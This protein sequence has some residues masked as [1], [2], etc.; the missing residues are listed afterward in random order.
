MYRKVI[1]KIKQQIKM[2][3]YPSAR[4]LYCLFFRV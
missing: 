4:P 2:L 1:P 3:T